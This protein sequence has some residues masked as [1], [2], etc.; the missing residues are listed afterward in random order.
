MQDD[1]IE[2]FSEEQVS[3]TL[4]PEASEPEY[5]DLAENINTHSVDEN[6]L[7]DIELETPMDDLMASNNDSETVLLNQNDTLK[8]RFDHEGPNE[9]NK[10]VLD[11]N[12]KNTKHVENLK[13]MEKYVTSHSYLLSISLKL[14]I[15]STVFTKYTG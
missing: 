10:D 6:T 14:Q 9:T 12:D 1:L 4:S 8:H 15:V 13:V 3:P 11:V 7:G 2:T 5:H